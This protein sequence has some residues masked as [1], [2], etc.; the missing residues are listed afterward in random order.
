MKH[1]KSL[2]GPGSE[3][4]LKRLQRG[5]RNASRRMTVRRA[6]SRLWRTLEAAGWMAVAA[7]FL[8]ALVTLLKT[9]AA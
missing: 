1:G 6:R 5:F 4:R 8:Y 9:Q 2:Q 7:G 3:E